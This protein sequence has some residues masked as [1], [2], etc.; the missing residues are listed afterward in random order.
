MGRRTWVVAGLLVIASASRSE[1]QASMVPEWL[2]RESEVLLGHREASLAATASLFESA[3]MTSPTPVL[4]RALVACHVLASDEGPH[5]RWDTFAD[6]DLRV[7]LV[8][9][10]SRRTAWGTENSMEAWVTFA[11]VRL[12][13]R[14]RIEVQLWDRDVTGDER[15]ATLRGA[16][17][18]TLP[19]TLS[20]DRNE[21][22]CTVVDPA[23]VTRE[24][25]A[26]LARAEPFVVAV[27]GAHPE[28]TDTALDRPQHDVEG[29]THEVAT[30]MGWGGLDE[31][32]ARA[33]RDR[34]VASEARF[35]REVVAALAALRRTPTTG[36]VAVP[37]A[38]STVR[39]VGVLTGHAAIRSAYPSAPESIPCVVELVLD[40]PPA[41]PVAV[42][43]APD[44]L[45]AHG[46]LVT[47]LETDRHASE[48]GRVG[49][50][51][52]MR[53]RPGTFVLRV[54]NGVRALIV[55]P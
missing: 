7:V 4:E 27:E 41:D 37:G 53:L 24:V 43:G 40:P 35:D 9:G 16:Y 36:P 52:T 1:G 19:I 17:G 15:M 5:G 2:G 10:R 12:D 55:P 13:T 18:G 30:A 44:A 33:L 28:L 23:R 22:T 54:G 21:V 31:A 8:A 47:A 3:A 14:M 46:T 20:D 48:A 45:D 38:T 50:P 34:L 25:D 51:F 42:L 29:A 32:R 11:G 49:L 6:P 39:Y 26:A